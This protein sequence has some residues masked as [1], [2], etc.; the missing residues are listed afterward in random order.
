VYENS[1]L[2]KEVIISYQKTIREIPL[3]LKQI[4]HL[5]SLKN[6]TFGYPF[7]LQIGQVSSFTH[8]GCETL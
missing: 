7:F 8:A 6:Y 2:A 1:I 5:K 3:V 4:K